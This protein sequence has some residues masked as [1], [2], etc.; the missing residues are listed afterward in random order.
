MKHVF[1]RSLLPLLAFCLLALGG[2]KTSTVEIFTLPSDYLKQR[3]IESRVLTTN[4]E[5]LILRSAVE[6]LQDIGYIFTESAHEFGIL[7]ASCRREADN[8]A[9]KAFVA[10]LITTLGALGGNPQQMAYEHEQYI[11]VSV[12]TR[13]VKD[14]TLVRTTFARQIFRTDGTSYIERIVDPEIYNGFYK[15]LAQSVFLTENAI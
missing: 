15:R 14:G 12:V 7:T 9:A 3:Q 6:V 13:K 10:T 2:C 11:L 1:S 4:D 5:G 8:A